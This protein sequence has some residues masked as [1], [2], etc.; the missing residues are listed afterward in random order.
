MSHMAASPLL[1]SPAVT[2]G[3]T[4]PLSSAGPIPAGVIDMGSPV[5]AAE[6][7]ATGEAEAGA[8]AGA[9]AAVSGCFSTDAAATAIPAQ[10]RTTPIPISSHHRRLDTMA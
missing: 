1:N 8:G 9:G 4:A 10:R 7:G 5:G 6:A 3:A 2:S